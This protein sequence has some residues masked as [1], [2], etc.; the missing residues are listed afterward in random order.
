VSPDSSGHPCGAALPWAASGHAIS[1]PP[2]AT[3]TIPL[4]RAAG[5]PAGALA[6]PPNTGNSNG[7]T[8]CIATAP[9]VQTSTPA[10]LGIRFKQPASHDGVT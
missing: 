1:P 4:P 10:G 9:S 5:L 2:A 6:R 7:T 8:A 3:V